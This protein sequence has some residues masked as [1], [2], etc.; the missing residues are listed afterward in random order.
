MTNQTKIFIPFTLALIF[1][2]SFANAQNERLTVESDSIEYDSDS[3]TSVFEGNVMI[4]RGGL[5]IDADKVEHF[6]STEEGDYIVAYGEPV[7]FTYESAERELKTQGF[8]VEA[9]YWFKTKTMRMTGDV[10]IKDERTTLR[11][12]EA[13]YNTETGEMRA[14]SRTAAGEDGGRLQST[15]VIDDN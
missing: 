5:K 15:I 3:G 2:C 14:I 10:L 12:H 9:I 8:S 11:A 7:E 4:A 13:V 6:K 1:F